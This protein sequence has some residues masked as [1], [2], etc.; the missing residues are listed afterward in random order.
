VVGIAD[1][2]PIPD[3]SY[4]EY[5]VDAE[6]DDLSDLGGAEGKAPNSWKQ[7]DFSLKQFGQR[8][9]QHN[10]SACNKLNNYGCLGVSRISISQLSWHRTI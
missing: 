2:H 1:L 7:R 8:M 6:S 3:I 10:I 4:G 9:G 5:Y